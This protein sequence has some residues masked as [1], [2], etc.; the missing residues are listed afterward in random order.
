M[1]ENYYFIFVANQEP[2]NLDRLLLKLGLAEY[3]PA[4]EVDLHHTNKPKTLYVGHYHNSL[5]FAHPDLPFQFFKAE[6]S[7]TEKK[8]IACFPDTEIAALIENTTVGLFGFSIIEKGRKIRMKDG[9][10]NKYFNDF[11]ELLP[12][13]KESRQEILLDEEEIE[14]LRE[15]GMEDDEIERHIQFQADWG[16]PN[17]ISKRYLGEY[18]GAIEA[19]KVK[20]IK[21]RIK[22]NNG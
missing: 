13:E 10:D 7:E 16:V 21:Y 15:D 17:L 14:G 12:E 11:G 22:Q 8:F 18:H 9:A 19:S 2:V 3:E 20:M 6:S 1:A 5:I 4:E